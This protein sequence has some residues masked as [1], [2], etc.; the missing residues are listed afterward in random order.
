MSWTEDSS[1]RRPEPY[2]DA[3]RARVLRAVM[4][5]LREHGDGPWREIAAGVL[6]GSITLRQIADSSA[7]RD[8]FAGQ[9][10]ALLAWRDEIGQDSFDNLGRQAGLTVDELARRLR[11]D[12]AES[13]YGE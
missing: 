4:R 3:A 5:H 9:G 2:A 13:R 10:S 7:Y 12:A 11:R 1:E 8:A 6:G